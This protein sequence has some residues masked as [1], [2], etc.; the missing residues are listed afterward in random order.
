MSQAFCHVKIDPLDYDPLGLEWRNGSY[1]N[2]C[3]PFRN[4][5]GSQIFQ[6]ISDAVCYVMPQKGFKVFKYVDDFI[7]VGMP[8]AV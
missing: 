2:T 8:D 1:I 6:R 3:L 7:G 4:R 5:H